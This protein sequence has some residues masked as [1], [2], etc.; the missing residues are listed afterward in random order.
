LSGQGLETEIVQ[1]Q[2]IN[3]QNFGQ[4]AGMRAIGAG[5]VQIQE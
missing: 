4:E 1:D 2:Q 5:S 3:A